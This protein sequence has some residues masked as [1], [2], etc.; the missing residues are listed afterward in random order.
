MLLPAM[1]L[2][3]LRYPAGS[4]WTVVCFPSE[5]ELQLLLSN[6]H[7]PL[8]Y[9]LVQ[10]SSPEKGRLLVPCSSNACFYDTRQTAL[11]PPDKPVLAL[12]W[13]GDL[14][15][16]EDIAE[17]TTGKGESPLRN[18]QGVCKGSNSTTLRPSVTVSPLPLWKS[19]SSCKASRTFSFKPVFHWL[20]SS[21]LVLNKIL[22]FIAVH[23]FTIHI[24]ST[25][26]FFSMPHYAEH[27]L[28][29]Q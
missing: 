25:A 23:L 5:L 13:H 18:F 2:Q 10:L 15:S 12:M 16:E 9:T 6:P 14:C 29:C 8:H 17:R 22:S 27:I 28:S 7:L 4:L 1:K 26:C 20:Q 11:W 3:L 21:F 19:F 24:Y